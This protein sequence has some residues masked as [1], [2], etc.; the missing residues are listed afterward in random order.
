M[1]IKRFN[2]ISALPHVMKVEDYV[3]PDKIWDE[4][5]VD[6]SC[7][8]P[9]DTQLATLKPMTASEQEQH[10][11]FVDGK[12][13]GRQMPLRRGADISELAQDIREKQKNIKKKLDSAAM[14]IVKEAEHKA[15]QEQVKAEL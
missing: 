2:T 9:L 3:I 15:M 10:F 13:D 1:K 5:I 8:I 6:K 7:F 11:D 14:N 4:S 12:D